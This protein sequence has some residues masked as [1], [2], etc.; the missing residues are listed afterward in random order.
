MGKGNSLN[1]KEMIKEG[2]LEHQEQ[3]K[4]N[5]KKKYRQIY[6]PSPL[7]FSELCLTVEAK[8][9][10]LSNVVLHVLEEIFKTIIL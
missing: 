4:N 7:E 6:F 1:R 10:A 8:I 3:R 5:S 9:I 2:V